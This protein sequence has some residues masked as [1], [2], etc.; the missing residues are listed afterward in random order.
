MD[1]YVRYVGPENFHSYDLNNKIVYTSLFDLASETEL[2]PCCIGSEYL[3]ITYRDLG[4]GPNGTNYI[5]IPPTYSGGDISVVY[6]FVSI[7]W[8]MSPITTFADQLCQAIV[9][10]IDARPSDW[11]EY[12]AFDEDMSFN[13][14]IMKYIGTV[15]IIYSGNDPAYDEIITKVPNV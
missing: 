8:T 12:Y 1:F 4:D 11:E 15:T 14:M 10:S 3:G 13:L 5:P 2:R 9:N 7:P 6:S